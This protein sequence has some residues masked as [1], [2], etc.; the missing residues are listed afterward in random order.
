MILSESQPSHTVESLR[1]FR[2]N[3]G[4][5]SVIKKS[6]PSSQIGLILYASRMLN[7]SQKVLK[8]RWR[9]HGNQPFLNHPQGILLDLFLLG[10]RKHPF[11]SIFP[12]SSPWINFVEPCHC[13]HCQFS[14]ASIC[15]MSTGYRY[16][17]KS[18]GYQDDMQCPGLVAQ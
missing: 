1:Y 9:V 7:C 8:V 2:D 4:H 3:E 17:A 5:I 14:T 12:L 16:C 10:T 15:P 11:L 18:C 6:S 13:I